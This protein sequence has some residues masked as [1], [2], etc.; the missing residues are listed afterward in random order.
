ML[1]SVR[2]G[3]VTRR[4]RRLCFLGDLAGTFPTALDSPWSLLGPRLRS[5]ACASFD[6]GKVDKVSLGDEVSLW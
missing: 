3:S 5:R 4:R 6:V 1:I 2:T